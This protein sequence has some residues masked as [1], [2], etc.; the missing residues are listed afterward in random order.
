M[1]YE[2]MIKHESSVADFSGRSPDVQA[3][4]LDEIGN[5]RWEL[6]CITGDAVKRNREL[7]FKRVKNER[8]T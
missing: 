8:G 3:V 6:V 7:Y 1:K 4:Q 5:D 2:Y